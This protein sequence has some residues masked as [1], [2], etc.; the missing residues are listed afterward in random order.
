M[1]RNASA[2]HNSEAEGLGKRCTAPQVSCGWLSAQRLLQIK[3]RHNN[4]SLLHNHQKSRKVCNRLAA[5]KIKGN[6][7]SKK[8][9]FSWDVCHRQY[10]DLQTSVLRQIG[11]LYDWT[12]LWQTWERPSADLQVTYGNASA[13]DW[14]QTL[15]TIKWSV[16]SL[17]FVKQICCRSAADLLVSY[18]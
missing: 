5:N 7:Q 14:K 12:D 3:C 16:A 17:F 9:S 4:R 1:T 10:A 8:K 13:T 6:T 15:Q 11:L 2:T 18:G